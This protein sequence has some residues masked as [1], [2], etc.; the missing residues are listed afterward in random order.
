MHRCLTTFRWTRTRRATC[1]WKRISWTKTARGS[2]QER[3]RWKILNCKKL[4]T[5]S[6]P[7]ILR[8][9]S[10]QCLF[11]ESVYSWFGAW[12]TS[13]LINVWQINVTLMFLTSDNAKGNQQINATNSANA[14]S[15]NFKTFQKRSS[16]SPIREIFNITTLGATRIDPRTKF[17][18]QYSQC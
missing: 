17:T 4:Q 13:C 7:Q 2:N 18:F 3:E 1:T 6:Q 9:Q 15:T 8:D 10:M 12:T 16:I 14:V 11:S 5:R